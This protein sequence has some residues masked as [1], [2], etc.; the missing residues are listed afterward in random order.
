MED[1]DRVG[2]V[3]RQV[4]LERAGDVFAAIEELEIVEPPGRVS[5]ESAR[6]E[7]R[8]NSLDVSGKTPYERRREEGLQRL[9]HVLSRC[10][11]RH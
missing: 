1:V 4:P 11:P 5:N 8:V 7:R 2:V 9:G 6:C 10:R 3:C